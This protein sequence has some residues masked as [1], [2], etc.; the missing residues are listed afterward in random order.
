M[1]TALFGVGLGIT[2]IT[3]MTA[4]MD[5]GSTTPMLATMIG[6][7]VGI[8]YALF[9]LARYRS[10]LDH[11]DDR[12]EATGIAVGTAGSAVVFAGLTVLIALSALGV[13]RI[14]FLTT[15]G[16]AA[17]AT[18]LIAVLVALTLLPAVPRADEVQGLRGSRTPHPAQARRPGHAAEQRGPLGP[19]RGPGARSRSWCWWWS[20]SARWPSRCQG[21]HLAFP[22]DSTAALGDH[23]AQGRGPDRRRPSAPDGTR[24]CCWSSTA[25]PSTP[26]TTRKAAYDEVVA[27]AAGQDGVANAQIA[28]QNEKGTGAQILVTPEYAG[29]D[30]RD[31]AAAG[32]P[33]RGPG[34]DRGADRRRRSG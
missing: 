10:E 17:A 22:S 1:L 5:I 23:P 8:D 28:G 7:G 20:G 26:R 25:A 9:I 2:G 34:R 11:T 6:L 24:R 30:A 27:W 12:E 19:A 21:L 15:M 4:F 31:R 14:P 29:D 33:S 16:I 32:G 3:A 13:A 18:V